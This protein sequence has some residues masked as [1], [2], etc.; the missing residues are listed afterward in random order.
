M[1]KLLQLL[2]IALTILITNTVFA[3]E[4]ISEKPGLYRREK[5]RS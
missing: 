3:E 2:T 4:N 5:W 1:I